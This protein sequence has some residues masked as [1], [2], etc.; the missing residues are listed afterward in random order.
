[1]GLVV[2]P[3]NCERKRA[4]SMVASY[5]PASSTPWRPTARTLGALFAGS[6]VTLSATVVHGGSLLTGDDLMGS[7]AEPSTSSN[8]ADAAQLPST[9]SP[10]ASLSAPGQAAP[11]TPG[12]A[13]KWGS[14]LQDLPVRRAPVQEV[15]RQSAPT[16]TPAVETAGSE[17]FTAVPTTPGHRADD[18]S[19]GSGGVAPQAADPQRTG[20][21]NGLVTNVF[22]VTNGLRH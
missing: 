21:F 16:R 4:R 12:A 14:S 9:S 10:T 15:P 19:P 6:A 5:S 3:V 2:R 22:S 18:A 8:V 20:P 1:M 7:V 13:P 11:W 17:S